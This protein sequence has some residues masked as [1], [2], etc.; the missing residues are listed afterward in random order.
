MH[1]FDL[2]GGGGLVEARYRDGG[3]CN[4]GG[5]GLGLGGELVQTLTIDE[6]NCPN[7]GFIHCDAQGAENHI[8]AAGIHTIAK[9]R[10]LIFYENNRKYNPLLFENV[11]RSYP[12][13]P[14]M[15][16]FDLEDYC[17]NE[18]QYSRVIHRFCG[19]PDDLLIP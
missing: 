2:D 14:S 13:Y 7:L 19:G 17:I 16:R 10:P 1:A 12:M 6:I 5:V 3:N 11:C 18:L 4:F 8:F 15:S 9:H